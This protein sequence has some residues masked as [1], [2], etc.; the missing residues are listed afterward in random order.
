MNPLTDEAPQHTAPTPEARATYTVAEVAN[1]LGLSRSGTYT[2]LRAGEIPARRMGSRW[3][4]PR[5]RFHAWL[6]DSQSGSVV[7]E[8][9]SRSEV[10]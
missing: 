9:R 3:I 2:L 4:I 1:L 8:Q 10:R 5:R 6:D 7:D